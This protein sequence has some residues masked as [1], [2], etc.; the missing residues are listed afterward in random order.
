ME[1]Y[2]VLLADDEEEIR[3][4]ISRKIDWDALGFTL[5]GQAENGAEALEMAEQLRP[6]V[7]LTD[8]KMPFMDGL[9][10]CRQLKPRLPAAKLVVFSGFDDFA[11]AQQA[12]G[13]EVSEYILKPINAAELESV[14]TRL[15]QQ[16]VE[17]RLARRDVETLR[18]RYA[19]SL[20]VL[21]ELFYNQLLDGRIPQSG[22][23]ER[24]ARYEIDLPEGCWTVAMVQAGGLHEETAAEQ[25]NLLLMSVQSFFDSQFS[26][27][28]CTPQLLLYNDQ[29]TLLVP[30]G[31]QERIYPLIAEL[32]R[33]CILA[34]S[35]LNTDLTVGVGLP[36]ANPGELRQSMEGARTALAYRVRMGTGCAIYIGDIEPDNPEPLALSEDDQR[37]LTTVIRLGTEEQLEALT[38]QLLNRAR[39]SRLPLP[40]CQLYFA[41]FYGAAV[42][43]D[44]SGPVLRAG[45]GYRVGPGGRRY[46][47]EQARLPGDDGA[48]VHQLLQTPA[49]AAQPPAQRFGGPDHRAGHRVHS[50]PLCRQRFERG[51][52][53]YLS[54]S[55]ALLF[56]HAV[57]AGDGDELHRL[58][59]A[60]ADGTGG[61]AA[62]PDRGKDV[63]DC[64]KNG[65][66]RPQLFQLCI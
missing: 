55:V 28:G 22:I 43:P 2:R 53:V 45:H 1:L 25:D 39:E 60:A 19:E 30:L 6:D 18:R 27:E 37:A 3:E 29:V 64:G 51:G 65:V 58:C 62:A 52:S 63:S 7:V 23:A 34:K 36:C 31:E 46:G 32:E 10:L 13:L 59:D 61:S 5:V 26:L 4:G 21:R 40:Q 17:E 33:L 66:C 12:I 47:F 48:L 41:V 57:Q 56:F 15:R 35:L 24:A 20:P 16:I 50:K 42:V 11:Y 14:L 8:I 38:A 54:A 9:E 49:G 44:P